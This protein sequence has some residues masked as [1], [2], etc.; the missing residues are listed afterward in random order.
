MKLTRL[1]MVITCALAVTA[2]SEEG[3]KLESSPAV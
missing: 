3:T 2:C 1:A